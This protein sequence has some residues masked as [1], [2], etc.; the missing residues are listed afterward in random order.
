MIA[1]YVIAATVLFT[2][3]D[4]A[5]FPL[6][7]NADGS[8]NA[9]RIP[10]R[11]SQIVL[12][13]GLYAA[14]WILGGW[15]CAAASALVWWTGVCDVLYYVF[16][17]P[18]SSFWRECRWYWLW[19]TPLGLVRRAGGTRDP[20]MSSSEVLWQAIIGVALSIPFLFF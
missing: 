8:P 12:Q 13:L 19:W 17:G 3:Y 4:Y 10:Y 11:V 16:D 7:D 15:S 1:F 5:L 2:A 18:R 9:W 20:L 14:C 6:T